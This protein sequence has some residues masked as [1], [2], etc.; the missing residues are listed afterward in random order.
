[1]AEKK[2][3]CTHRIGNPKSG[4]KRPRPIAFKF[5]RYNTKTKV[6]GNEK[7]LEFQLPKA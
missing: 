1:M 3:D 7:I 2:L 4:N 6:F 5:T